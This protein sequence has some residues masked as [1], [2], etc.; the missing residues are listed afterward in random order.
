VDR[1]WH[2]QDSINS[3]IPDYRFCVL[4]HLHNKRFAV[5]NQHGEYV[6]IFAQRV[7]QP[8]SC[9]SQYL[10]NTDTNPNSSRRVPYEQT[11]YGR[12]RIQA[13]RLRYPSLALGL[14]DPL[15]EDGNLV[16][17]EKYGRLHYK[18][19][20]KLI[21]QRKHTC[22]DMV[23]TG[24]SSWV[25]Y[26]PKRRCLELYEVPRITDTER[27]T[28]CTPSYEHAWGLNGLEVDAYSADGQLMYMGADSNQVGFLDT[29]RG[30]VHI[31]NTSGTLNKVINS[32]DKDHKIVNAQYMPVSRN[33]CTVEVPR[34][35]D[36]FAKSFDCQIYVQRICR[37]G[38]TVDFTVKPGHFSSVDGLL[39][40]E[41]S[42]QL[43]VLGEGCDGP[44]LYMVS[45]A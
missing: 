26:S 41:E 7:A 15:A 13:L 34:D 18:D 45:F 42:K 6:F 3:C 2:F 32:Q 28:D 35:R 21:E 20:S 44:G 23:Q 27:K 24:S 38:G 16:P 37:K 36:D 22:T 11:M 4:A 12:M 43:F 10:I 33:L 30:E 9:I 40:Y 14:F 25:L 1:V 17:L 5:S 39:F 31:Y 19:V 8:P 29:Y